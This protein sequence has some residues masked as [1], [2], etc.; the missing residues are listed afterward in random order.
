ME[1]FLYQ[2]MFCGD[3]DKNSNT[4]TLF[5]ALI[6]VDAGH[7]VVMALAVPKRKKAT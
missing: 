7:V 4:D 6:V 5:F 3:S 2:V 1:T